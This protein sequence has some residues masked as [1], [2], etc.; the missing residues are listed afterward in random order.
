MEGLVPVQ[1]DST[2]VDSLGP[3][4][5]LIHLAVDSDD[6]ERLA[7]AASDTLARPVAV[8]GRAL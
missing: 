6:S 3:L 1:V 5:S 8:V 7:A 2:A 4:A